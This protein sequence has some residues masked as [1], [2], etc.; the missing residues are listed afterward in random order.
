MSARPCRIAIAIPAFDEEALIGRCLDAIARQQGVD[1]CTVIVFANNCSD[2]TAD[3]ARAPRTI[4]VRVIEADLSPGERHAG[5]AR[6]LAMA[7]AAE[8]GEIILTTDADCIPDRGWLAAH[9][10]AFALGAD[11]VAGRVSADWDE[12]R[13][14]PHEALRI[15]ALEWEYLGLMGEAE[16]LFD[17]RPHDPAPRHAQ[18]CGA[19]LAITREMLERIG[20]VPT[21]AVGEDRAL[22][23][24]V[25]RHDGRIRFDRAAHVTA[26]ARTS[27]RAD[28]GMA[29]ALAARSARDYRCDDQFAAADLLVRFWR[30]RAAARDAWSYGASARPT[31]D[32][33]IHIDRNFETFGAAWADHLSRLPQPSRLR[34]DRLP[35][36]IVRMRKLIAQYG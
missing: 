1:E 33:A 16:A 7:N 23:A 17:P 34:P 6:R 12:L 28:G 18:R 4:E 31:G 27:G 26:S 22:L 30:E 14:Q 25:E 24:A 15:G 29:D 9:R 13:H 5:R 36:E 11:A 3:I 19:N 21:I 2:R 32:Q 35:D 20:G 10:R 8:Q